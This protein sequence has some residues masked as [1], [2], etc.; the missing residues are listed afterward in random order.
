AARNIAVGG[1]QGAVLLTRG[2]TAPLHRLLGHTA[3][4]LSV[5]FSPD[6]KRI[7][8]GSDD[9][10]AKVWDVESGKEML[11][12]AR[13]KGAVTS[14]EFSS[15]GRSVL[16]A[17]RDALAIVGPSDVIKPAVRTTRD[18]FDYQIDDQNLGAVA[19]IDDGI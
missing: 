8:T 13:H 10:T 15:D 4:V 18:R 11:S 12:L 9:F 3:A 7:A 16:T 19:V 5:A 2:E 6:G 17:G 1:T 14:V